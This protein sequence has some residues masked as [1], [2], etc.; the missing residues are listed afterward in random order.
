[1]QIHSNK[2]KRRQNDLWELCAIYADENTSQNLSKSILNNAKKNGLWK[3]T[4]NQKV[5]DEKC[6]NLQ[7][8]LMK[9]LQAGENRTEMNIMMKH[10]KNT[11]KKH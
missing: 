2:R 11:M 7:R 5:K 4:R 9:L 3:K 1:M 8:N 10:L 6:L